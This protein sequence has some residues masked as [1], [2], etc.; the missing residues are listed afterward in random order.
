MFDSALSG[1]AFSLCALGG[2]RN[3][4]E[5]LLVITSLFNPVP[6]D[7][8][9]FLQK[10]DTVVVFMYGFLYQNYN[11]FLLCGGRILNFTYNIENG[12]VSL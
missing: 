1:T 8:N 6:H 9:F 5:Y 12:N 4:T 7:F 2:C 10:N 11:F 3:N